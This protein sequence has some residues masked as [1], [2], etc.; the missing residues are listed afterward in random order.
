M[1]TRAQLR[2]ARAHPHPRTLSHTREGRRGIPRAGKGEFYERPA[3]C[4]DERGAVMR[5]M[6]KAMVEPRSL[7][8]AAQRALL[9]A[10]LAQAALAG[11]ALWI[12][13]GLW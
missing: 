9:A 10:L 2:A 13:D 1:L 4:P 3:G 8:G 12:L 6:T 7:A 5:A 11:A